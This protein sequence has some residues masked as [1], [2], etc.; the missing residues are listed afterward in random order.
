MK[1]I[2]IKKSILSKVAVIAFM[3]TMGSYTYGNHCETNEKKIN[4]ITA[5]IVSGERIL[6]DF[7][8]SNVK[9]P[10]NTF[11]AALGTMLQDL[12]R[13]AEAL[14]RSHHD[15]LTTAI[16]ELEDY[17]LQQFNI[18]LNV[19]KKYNGK[20]NSQAANFALE[21]RKEFDTEKVFS[22]MITKLKAIK[23]KAAHTDDK[24]LAKEI[25]R[26]IQIIQKKKG[27]W[28]AKPDWVL[29][30]GLIHRMKC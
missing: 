9:T 28:S 5:V 6:A 23:I 30:G 3:L 16:D 26:L 14:T 12:Q 7:V 17:T 4:N 11:L 2:I 22:E 15:D 19:F 18:L 20:P 25:D 13:K 27:E 1:N 29:L 8:N 21:I 10:F 24:H